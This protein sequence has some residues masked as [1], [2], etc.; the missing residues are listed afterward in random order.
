VIQL[1]PLAHRVPAGLAVLRTRHDGA[2]PE[3]VTR[4]DL[5]AIVPLNYADT[6]ASRYDVRVWELPGVATRYDVRMLWHR[7]ATSDAAHCWLRAVLRRL[8]QRSASR[9]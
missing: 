8:F 6:L 3:L 7:S 5:L 2:L 1:D 9:P 4:I